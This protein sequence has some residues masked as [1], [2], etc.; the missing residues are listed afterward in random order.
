MFC[1]HQYLWTVQNKY[2]NKSQ[3]YKIKSSTLPM[4][5]LLMSK[6]SW[7]KKTKL[8]KQVFKIY[9]LNMFCIHQYL[10]TVQNKYNKKSQC[11][12]I[13]SSALLMWGLQMFKVSW[14]KK[15][16]LLKRLFKIY[17]LNMF[18]HQY[19]WTVQNKYNKKS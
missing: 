4:W 13:K 6:V 18:M 7:K 1:M 11:Y 19:L 15:N 9:N 2:N 14:K 3:C 12:K 8:L 16:K 17:N 5:G 10:W